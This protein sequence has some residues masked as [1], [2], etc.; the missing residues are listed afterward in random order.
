VIEARGRLADDLAG[1]HRAYGETAA[2]RREAW[3]RAYEQLR[4]S[5]DSITAIKTSCDNTVAHLDAEL[6]RLRGEIEA[7]KVELAHIDVAL[8]ATHAD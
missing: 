5:G 3:H 6:D 2:G 1:A 8:G 4:F 7:M